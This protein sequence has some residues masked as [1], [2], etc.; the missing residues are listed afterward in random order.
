M[1][2]AKKNAPESIRGSNASGIQGNPLREV[3]RET[4]DKAIISAKR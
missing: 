2:L 1:M 3:K 4:K